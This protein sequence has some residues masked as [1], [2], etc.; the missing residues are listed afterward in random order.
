MNGTE[1]EGSL[2]SSGGEFF[3][4]VNKKLREAAGVEPGDEVAVAVEPADLEPV[5]PPA[6]LADA[7]RGEPDAAA[8]F[9]GLSGFYQRQ[10]TGWIAGAKSADTRSSRAAEVVALLK[11]GRKQR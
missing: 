8:F 3:F 5:R 6:E 7:L 9:D 2:G 4:P 10:Y 1:F 11:Q